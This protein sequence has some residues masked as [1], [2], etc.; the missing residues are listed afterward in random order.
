MTADRTGSLVLDSQ[1]DNELV[2]VHQPGT[3]Q[4]AASLLPLSV[5]VDDTLFAGLTPSTLLV[6]D[7]EDPAPG[8]PGTVYEIH[9]P[10]AP[11]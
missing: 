5:S 3:A 1:A 4:Q 11:G 9:G 8:T 2:F 7:L 6:S 10:F